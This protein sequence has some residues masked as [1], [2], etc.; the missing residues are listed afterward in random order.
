VPQ[1]LADFIKHNV[2]FIQSKKRVVL[3]YS[4]GLDSSVLLHLL[5]KCIE[6]NRLLLWHVNHQLQTCSID[7]EL[8][9]NRQAAEYQ[10]P[11]K[12]SRL[13]LS[14]VT[15]NIESQARDARYAVFIDE[16]N[17]KQDV[18][19]T[20]HH[21]DD[22]LETVLLNLCRGS[23]VL[24]LRG[25]AKE[26]FIEG[27]KCYRPLLE[28]SQKHLIDFAAK[29]RI[30]WMD[31][32][33]NDLDCFDRNY[34]RHELAPRF[35]TRWP[36]IVKSFSQVASHQKEAAEC[37]ES[38]ALMDIDSCQIESKYSKRLVLSVADIHIL[39]IARQKN[40]LRYW[41][42]LAHISMS[43]QQMTILLRVIK[44]YNLAYKKVELGLNFIALFEAKI[45]LVL[46]DD[47]LS[48]KQIL[49]WLDHHENEDYVGRINKDVKQVS[50]HFFKRQFQSAK[51]P[52]WL[53]DQTFF[54]L[55]GGSKHHQEM[56]VL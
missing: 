56:I 6:P 14:H 24:G 4:G 19:L 35:K 23:G 36:S 44:E 47:V 34:V 28:Q 52:P 9:C 32:P 11:F 38:L 7:M 13:D 22:Q 33:S 49:T 1:L 31:D 2:G 46:N 53:R 29:E 18:L 54:K 12:A 45:Y 25:I 3:A 15:N 39:S 41:M 40:V 17:P 10:L 42:S 16:L 55:K 43:L 51:V 37:L 8:F 30:K 27:L 48:T 50:S 21:A 5:S 26:R 20:A